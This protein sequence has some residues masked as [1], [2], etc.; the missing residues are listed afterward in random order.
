[1]KW[2]PFSGGKVKRHNYIAKGLG[3]RNSVINRPGS[4]ELINQYKYD[5]LLPRII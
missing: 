5:P 4:Q 1:M 3:P 2:D